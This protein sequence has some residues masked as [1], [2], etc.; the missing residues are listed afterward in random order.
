[1]A[2]AVVALHG[3]LPLPLYL[4]LPTTT[5]TTTITTITITTIVTTIIHMF[6]LKLHLHLHL[7]LGKVLLHLN[8]VLWPLQEVCL[9]QGEVLMLNLRNANPGIER[10]LAKILENSLV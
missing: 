4:I 8:L 6:F 10:D 2:P 5:T 7:Q 3:H 1:M 9:A